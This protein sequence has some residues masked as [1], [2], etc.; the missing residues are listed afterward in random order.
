M[1]NLTLDEL[2]ELD[3]FM[4]AAIVDSESGMTLATLGTAID[5]EIAAAGNTEVVKAKRKV[6]EALGLKDN[7]ED[8]LITLKN[9]YHLIRP[10]S[11]NES[12]FLYLVLNR[13][14]ASLGLARLTLERFENGLDF[15]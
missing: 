10:L 5:L 8:I 9:Q 7:I 12:L 3:G 13:K 1:A 14:Q 11:R 15:S 2:N 6:A 4:A